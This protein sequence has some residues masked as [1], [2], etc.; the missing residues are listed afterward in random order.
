M[1]TILSESPNCRFISSAS[2]FSNAGGS[3]SFLAGEAAAA[4]GLLVIGVGFAAGAG[5]VEGFA[6]GFV[7]APEVVEGGLDVEA[8]VV[9]FL[10]SSLLLV[11]LLL[12]LLYL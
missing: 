12:M 6:G 2:P 4:A 10:G 9:G 8:V 3:G 7:V 1:K 11:L 5:G